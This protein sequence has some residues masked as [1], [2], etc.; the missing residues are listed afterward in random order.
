M[1]ID[2]TVQNKNMK[3]EVRDSFRAYGQIMH[4]GLNVVLTILLGFGLGKLLDI[5]LDTNFIYIIGIIL[6]TIVAIINFFISL[7]KV[8]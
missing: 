5:F 8:K 2:F 4:L 7:T 3:K 1:E 6:F